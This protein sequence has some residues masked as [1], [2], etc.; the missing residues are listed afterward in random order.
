MGSSAGSTYPTNT[1]L[2]NCTY[3][4]CQRKK[5]RGCGDAA[6]SEQATLYCVCD[7]FLFTLTLVV[8]VSVSGTLLPVGVCV[9]DLLIFLHERT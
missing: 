1:G 4:C 2:Y 7:L 9:R 3:L 5:R 8:C 6:A